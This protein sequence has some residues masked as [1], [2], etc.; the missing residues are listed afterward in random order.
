MIMALMSPYWL[1]QIKSSSWGVCIFVCA[2]IFL[3]L[4]IVKTA[5]GIG[6]VLYCGNLHNLDLRQRLVDQSFGDKASAITSIDPDDSLAE[7]GRYTA[8]EGRIVG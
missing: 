5:V 3:L 2:V 6:L 8:V 4:L 7:I 1:E